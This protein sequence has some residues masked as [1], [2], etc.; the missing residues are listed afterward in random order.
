MH[1]A[2][3]T[4]SGSCLKQGEVCALVRVAR[5]QLDAMS[6]EAEGEMNVFSSLLGGSEVCVRVSGVL[7]G[8]LVQ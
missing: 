1:S 3:V 7:A 6:V 4:A 5:R 8:V 2:D